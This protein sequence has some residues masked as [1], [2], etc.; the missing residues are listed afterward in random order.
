M[1]KP[2]RFQLAG[3]R[4]RKAE[5]LRRGLPPGG[6]FRIEVPQGTV[7]LDEWREG[8]YLII[9]DEA[10]GEDGKAACWFELSPDPCPTA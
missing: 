6:Y 5:L 3:A 1:G 2:N 4:A 8:D 7:P 9:A 10:R